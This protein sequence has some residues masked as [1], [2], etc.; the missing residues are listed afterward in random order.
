MRAFK[1]ADAFL[2]SDLVLRRVAGGCSA[3]E[4]ERRSHAWRP[5]RAYA[6]MLLWQIAVDETINGGA[7]PMDGVL[8]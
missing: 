7:T 1:A 3:G 4:L 6:V 2:P 8:L 5:W